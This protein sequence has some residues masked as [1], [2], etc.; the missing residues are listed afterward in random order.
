MF[1]Q[2]SR[3]QKNLSRRRRRG[4]TTPRRVTFPKTNAHDS[5]AFLFSSCTSRSP[6]NRTLD[7]SIPIE[8]ARL[9]SSASLDFENASARNRRHHSESCRRVRAVA[10][11]R[12][13]HER[14]N[15]RC[16]H[17]RRARAEDRGVARRRRARHRGELCI[18]PARKNARSR[19][20][21]ART[22][23]GDASGGEGAVGV[24]R[25]P[26]SRATR[27]RGTKGR[28]RGGGDPL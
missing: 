2:A 8:T 11:T 7:R 25:V 4:M 19:V 17:R 20:A 1:L 13:N 10:S 3:R 9:V 6:P 16:A 28:T 26:A 18:C 15:R 22:A 23:R 5:P 27:G 12:A 24:W 21:R 14:E